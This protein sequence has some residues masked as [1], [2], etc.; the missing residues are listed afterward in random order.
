MI[1]VMIIVATIL[2]SLITIKMTCSKFS[3]INYYEDKIKRWS[4]TPRGDYFEKK[5]RELER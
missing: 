5:L 1:L 3:R 4:G 2:L